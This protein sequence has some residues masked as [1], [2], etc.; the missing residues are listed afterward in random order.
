MDMNNDNLVGT[1]LGKYEIR[2]AIGRGGM[3]VVY[4]GY[5]P[6]LDRHVALKVLAPHLLWESA[7]V[8]R[9]L[10]EARAAARLRHPNI[11]TI[12]DVGQEAG[13]YYFVMEFL[14]GQ[15]LTE[16]IRQRGPLSPN[17]TLA[18]L[19][20][21][22]RALDYA[23]QQGLVHRDIKPANVILAPNGQVTLTDFGIAQAAQETRLTTTGAIVGT[24][25]YMSPEQA[26]G[27][28]V[29]ART[30]QYSLAVVAFEMLSGQVPFQANSTLGLLYKITEEPPLSISE[31][32]PGLPAPVQRVLNK[33]LAKNPP[34]RF[35]S[36]T[37]F[38]ETLSRALAGQAVPITA[39]TL[40]STT[41]ARS[42]PVATKRE[43]PPPQ[44]PIWGRVPA[45]GWVLSALAVLALLVGGWQFLGGGSAA[46]PEPSPRSALLAEVTVPPTPTPQP[47]LTT[48]VKGT[49]AA[50]TRTAAAK[51]ADA[52]TLTAT[53]SATP[54]ATAQPTQTPA[55]TDTPA[56]KLQITPTKAPSRTPSSTS[57]PTVTMP[58]K[59]TS[60]PGLPSSTPGLL[61]PTP[62][63]TASGALITFEQMGTWRRGDQPYG[64]LT[65]TQKQVRSGSY[66]A[67]LR[68]D[69]PATDQ[70]F[71][72]FAQPL[73]LA[74][75]PDTVEAWVYGD[76]SGNFLNVWVEDAQNQIWSVHLGKV[77]GPGWQQM[78]G[79]LDPSLD[80]PSGPVSGPENGI[81]DYPVRFYALVLDRP[82]SAPQKGA[83]FID[84]ISVWRGEPG[85]EAP[86]TPVAA[87][88]TPTSI[89]TEPTPSA[90]ADVPPPGEV[91]HIVFTVQAGD[92]YYLYSTDPTWNE[93]VQ[94]GL[95]DWD[96]STCA[97]GGT[98]STLEGFATNLPGVNKCNITD[99][100]DAC[101][102]PD[103]QYKVVTD[104]KED[105]HTLALW[106]ALTNAILEGY[107]HGPLN[108][109]AGIEWAPNSRRFLFTIGRSVHT[110]Q[111]GSAG[112]L[113]IIPEIDDIWPPQYTPDGSLV[114]Y[115]KP[116]GSEGASDILV[117]SPDGANPR[118]LTNAPTAHK[119]CPRWRP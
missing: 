108:K 58:P 50:S 71:V 94:I 75:Q 109:T 81:I 14:E 68:Y 45:W 43:P 103:G 8:E 37:A 69:F 59:A 65:Q 99:R 70:D 85:A 96:H 41:D 84:D 12:Y 63:Q 61:T 62:G 31:I 15:T 116:V 51:T 66:A 7:F 40:G 57:A 79:R 93:M 10:R 27:L 23:H 87:I 110:A 107:Y 117:V 16:F 17:E 105:G 49:S 86:A 52:P 44:K 118:N 90:V 3:G 13:W 83:I 30:D 80:W 100:V 35:P 20:P 24:P 56:H 111:V 42:H 55:P 2:A 9:F 32:R 34:D 18:I 22:A 36:L 19:S 114:Y 102:S 73:N 46:Q 106:D 64:E 38:V 119:L 115:L 47:S 33:A 89:A 97:G 72:V 53:A 104:R 91:G 54:S 28:A 21:L 11:V 48:D 95:T 98:A 78:V 25:E 5:D 88:P 67:E 92:A 60:T 112:Y 39:Q 113:Q 76:G 74:G 6:L 101:L 29:D 77:A 82:G 26:K 4:H 1:K